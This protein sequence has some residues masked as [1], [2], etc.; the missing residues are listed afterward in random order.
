MSL[1]KKRERKKKKVSDQPCE[2]KCTRLR[3]KRPKT[4]SEPKL[5]Y[6]LK[7]RNGI[8]IRKGAK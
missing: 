2:S 5:N 1:K 6:V 8:T 7:K 3:T 4:P